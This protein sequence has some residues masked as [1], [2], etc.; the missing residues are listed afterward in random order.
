MKKS[1]YKLG[2]CA[3]AAFTLTL[4]ACSDK[5]AA[6]TEEDPTLD[7]QTQVEQEATGVDDVAQVTEGVNSADISDDPM[8]NDDVAVASADDDI[9]IA[10][11]DDADVLD[12]SESEEH[13]ST[14]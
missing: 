1:T 10:T 6:T 8:V 3:A 14:Y 5:G 13:V 7:P 4:S 12:G 11:V 9:A 2:L